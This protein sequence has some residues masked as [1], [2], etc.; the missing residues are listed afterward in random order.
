MEQQFSNAYQ[1]V[2]DKFDN[3]ECVVLDGGIGTELQ[4]QGVQDFRLSD[5]SHWGFEAIAYA[6]HAVV[7]VH[8]QYVR[9]GC[10]VVSTDTYAILDAPEIVGAHPNQRNRPIH[11]MDMARK[12]V[13]LA[14]DAIESCGKEEQCAVAFSIGGDIVTDQQ[15]GTVRLLLRVFKDTKPDLV[16]FETLS[17]MTDNRT[18]AALE[19]LVDS[20]IPVWLSFRRCRHGVCGIYGQLWGG[21]EGDYFGRLAHDLQQ[22]GAQAILVNCLPVEMVSGTIPWLRDFTDLPLG[23]YPNLGRYFDPHWKFDD[24]IAPADYAD[25][26]LIWRAEGAQILGG[27]CGAGPDHIQ[28]MAKALAGTKPSA[29]VGEG[30][31]DL[32]EAVGQRV[33]RLYEPQAEVETWTDEQDRIVYP[34]PLPELTC[35]PEVF[36]PTQGSYLLWK[37]LFNTGAGRGKRCLDVGCGAG[38]LTTQLALNGAEHVTAIDIQ[39]EAVANTLTNAFRNG[40]SDRVHGEVV[41]L[42]AFEI[43][44]RYDVVVAS[45]YQ[46]PTD[47]VG[48]LSGHRPLDYWGRNLF[49]HLIGQLPHMLEDGGVAYVMQISLLSQEQTAQLFREAGLESRVIDFNLYNFSPVFLENMEQIRRVEDCSD[50]YHFTLQDQHVMVM[51][52]LEVRRASSA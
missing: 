27:C 51:Y 28:A 9:A 46:M 24:S 48:E 21:P 29:P 2:L 5:T 52:L 44:K 20:G 3:E 33:D 10:D 25:T 40:V 47:P 43:E 18:K 37:M 39:K 23:A 30:R 7:N 14:R 6:P 17:M 31:L 34:L 36:V 41:D 45:L 35:D 15:L 1:R 26:A 16:L 13:L 12:G 4:R 42:Y 50:A 38:I 22:M 11:W 8:K 32:S 49:D 19:L